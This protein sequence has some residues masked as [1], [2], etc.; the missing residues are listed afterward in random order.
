MLSLLKRTAMDLS[1]LRR[2]RDFRLIFIG[3]VVSSIGTMISFVAVPFQIYEL[4]HSSLAVGLVGALEFFPI[5][6]LSFVGGAIADAMDRRKIM[7]GTDLVLMLGAIALA[8][9]AM[10]D[11]PQLW[12]IYAVGVLMTS[13]DC[14]Q[15]PAMEAVIP[16]VV[17]AE[18]MTAAAAIN[19][20]QR[21]LGMV[22]GPAIGGLLIAGVGLRWTFW[23]DA[24][25]Y[26]FSAA[27]VAMIHL[28]GAPEGAERPSFRRIKEGIAFARSRQQLMG[29][30]VVDIIAMVF[31]MPIAL[32]PAIA[33][34]YGGAEVLGLLTGAPAVGALLASVTSGWTSR[35]RRHGMAVTYAA[36]GWGA[37][38]ALF[39]L[40]NNLAL[41]LF[42]LALAGA[43]D[44]ISGVFRMTIWNHTIPDELRGRL[45][46]IELMSYS[47]G[48]ALSGVE[49]GVVARAFTPRVSV[50]SGGILCI[51]G[52]I[53]ATL[54]LP[55]YR[56]YVGPSGASEKDLVDLENAEIPPHV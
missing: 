55:G 16:R 51:A 50:V 44:M 12:V 38:I 43:S 47:V 40:S 30:Y 29:T 46:G 31:G 49:S 37:A 28:R 48:P 27:M 35:V 1:P 41:A 3:Q 13:V 21:S 6:T 56:N 10:L 15:R 36:C 24:A 26:A 14:L 54:M 34:G 42:F 7:I 17:P 9:N 19:G 22:V 20:S 39:G 11:K 53:I 32:F 4:T 23:L 18:D 45:A 8:L 25:S 2:H 52:A 33:D 5:I